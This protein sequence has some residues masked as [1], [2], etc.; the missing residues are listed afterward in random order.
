MSSAIIALAANKGGVGKTTIALEVAYLLGGVLVDLD[1]DQGGAS[2]AWGY[3]PEAR[4]RSQLLAALNGSSKAPQPVHGAGRPALVP[5]HP[6]LSEATI[7]PELLAEKLTSW[8]AAWPEPYVV[9]DTH[10]GATALSYGAMAAANL[11]VVPVVLGNRELDALG[12][13]LAEFRTFRLLLIP[14]R[15][16]AYPDARQIDR[17]DA[18]AS[19]YGVTVGPP[20]LDHRWLPRRRH[21]TTL[22]SVKDPGERVAAAVGQ[23]TAVVDAIK[24]HAA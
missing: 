1:W 18:L 6:L 14:N 22:S 2:R 10:P 11:V 13:M 9:V 5:S 21:R 20:I 7:A 17:L 8:A 3:D 19:E 15:V 12:G 4:S 23:F 24:E 16:P